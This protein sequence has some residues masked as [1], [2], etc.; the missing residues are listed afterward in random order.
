M[1]FIIKTADPEFLKDKISSTIDT[2]CERFKNSLKRNDK[3]IRFTSN[4]GDKYIFISDLIALKVVGNHKLEVVSKHQVFNCKGSLGKIEAEVP[5]YFIR[6]R[7]DILVN[8][9]E[10]IECATKKGIIT[11]TNG[12]TISCSRWQINKFKPILEKFKKR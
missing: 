1:N 11:M 3:E 2:I 8:L 4:R 10:V 12:F 6:C 9:N 5:N 7:R